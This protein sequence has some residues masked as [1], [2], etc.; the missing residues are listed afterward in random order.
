MLLATHNH[1]PTYS[2]TDSLTHSQSFTLTHTGLHSQPVKNEQFCVIKYSHH[3]INL[4]VTDV[5]KIIR[6]KIIFT[7][8]RCDDDNEE[9]EEKEDDDNSKN[10]NNDDNYYNQSEFI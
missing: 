1:S 10:N 6:D 4:L 8:R 3:L 2:P 7:T 5:Q 9:E